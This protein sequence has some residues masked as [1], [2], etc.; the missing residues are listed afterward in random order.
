MNCVCTRHVRNASNKV[1]CPIFCVVVSRR[2]DAFVLNISTLFDLL[3][4]L[5]FSG[6]RKDV[7]SSQEL[8]VASLLYGM[9]WLLILKRY[10][11]CLLQMFCCVDCCCYD[12]LFS[13]KWLYILFV[14]AHDT[15]VRAMVWDHSGQWM[16]TGEHAGY[17]KYWQNNMNNVKMYQA[18]KDAIRGLRLV[19]LVP[20]RLVSPSSF[21]WAP[22]FCS[23]NFQCLPYQFLK[24]QC[25]SLMIKLEQC[26]VFN[27]V[28]L[29]A[30]FCSNSY[31]SLIKCL[32]K[33]L[34]ATKAIFCLQ[35][36][37]S[38]N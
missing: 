15:S 32:N 11:R 3:K 6:L 37:F 24:L 16:I 36:E 18:H 22:N 4:L 1:K 7:A 25:I 21:N 13:V 34:L 5:S 28:V 31:D 29:Q 14:Q 8:P 27:Y 17:V 26:I 12:S 20:A 23:N 10:C 19:N 33:N 9:E 2:Y 35:H 38:A 30:M